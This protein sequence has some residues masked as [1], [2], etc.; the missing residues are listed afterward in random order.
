MSFNQDE[1]D[2]SIDAKTYALVLP[3]TLTEPPDI[4]TPLLKVNSLSLL[5]R[6]PYRRR[7][8]ERQQDA[9]HQD[10]SK[11]GLVFLH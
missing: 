7:Q 6:E 10:M 2:K 8:G 5:H 1:P 11:S 3:R 9:T 4:P